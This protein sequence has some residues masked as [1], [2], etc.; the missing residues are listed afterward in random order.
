MAGIPKSVRLAKQAYEQA[1]QKANEAANAASYIGHTPEAQKRADEYYH[2][3][4]AE[5][6]RAYDAYMKAKHDHA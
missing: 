6:N 1:R 3:C 2:K 4:A 5:A